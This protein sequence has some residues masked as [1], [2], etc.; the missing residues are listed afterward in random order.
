MHTMNLDTLLH[1]TRIKVL[2]LDMCT[3]MTSISKIA[4]QMW[5]NHPLAKEIR[6]QNEQWGWELDATGKGGGWTKFEKGR[7]RQ[8]RGGVFI[9]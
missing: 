9:N 5:C 3:C 6:Q 8:Y 1:K 4:H 2:R 7:G